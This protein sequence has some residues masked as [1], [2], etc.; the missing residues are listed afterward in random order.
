MRAFEGEDLL[1][2]VSWGGLLLGSAL[3]SSL[4]TW[5]DLVARHKRR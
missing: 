2:F 4:R 5:D 1:W 3:D